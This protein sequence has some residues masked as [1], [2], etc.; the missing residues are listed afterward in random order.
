MK[1]KQ[2][3]KWPSNRLNRLI[4]FCLPTNFFVP[5]AYF[6]KIEVNFKIHMCAIKWNKIHVTQCLG[7]AF[8]KKFESHNP[9][10]G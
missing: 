2:L 6:E 8:L 3:V 9:Y 4:T 10:F 5:I 1:Q 7:L